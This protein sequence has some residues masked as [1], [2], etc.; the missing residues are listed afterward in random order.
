M[1]HTSPNTGNVASAS[2]AEAGRDPTPVEQIKAKYNWQLRSCWGVEPGNLLVG[3]DADGIQLRVLAHY[4]ADADPDYA[5]AIENGDKAKETDIHNVNK[6][7]LGDVCRS[8]DVAK[9]FIYAWIL[10]ASAGKIAS[11]LNCTTAQATEA[12]GS[13]L[14]STPGLVYIKNELIPLDTSKGFFIGLDGRPVLCNSAHHM[15]AGYLQNG[16]AVIMKK[17][18]IKWRNDLNKSG[19]WYKQVNSVHD[20]WQTEVKG[21]KSIAEYVGRR[22]ARSIAWAGKELALKCKLEGSFNIGK[23]WYETH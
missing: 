19:T 12:M 5:F 11:I 2:R 21:H 15:L 22:Q 7:K 18:N 3:T 16:E 4:L 13:F 1:A 23:N 14:E 10:G 17:A 20:E 6:R 8:R 9:T